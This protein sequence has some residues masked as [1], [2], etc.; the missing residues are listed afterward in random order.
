MRRLQW[1]ALISLTLACQL[2]GKQSAPGPAQTLPAR[3]GPIAEGE[4]LLADGQLDGALAQFEQAGEPQSFYYRGLVWAKKAEL[5]PLPTPYPLAPERPN[6]KASIP[7][8][9]AEEQR[10]IELYEKGIAADPNSARTY[11]ALAQ[12]LAPHAARRHDLSQ[13]RIK[14]GRAA[15][16]APAASGAEAIQP[17]RVLDL[18]RKAAALEPSA[19]EPVESLVAF[20]SRVNRRDELE[21]GLQEMLKR[22]RERPDPYIRY[23]DFLNNQRQDPTGAIE[24]Y[25]QALIWKPDDEVTRA[26]VAD[27][28]INM[29]RESFAKLQYAAT[30][31]RLAEAQKYVSD[32]NSPQGIKIQDLA[33]RLA[34][35][36]QQHN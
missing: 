35:I 2:P 21:W 28:Y 29:A 31:Q 33:G 6:E 17:Q 36:R 11:S 24:Q 1:S 20:A 27:I 23:G 9:K 18:W 16:V 5:A 12:L 32:R 13:A 26:K 25:R 7:E 15:A 30:E 10:A 22:D 3:S 4:R 8:F 19:K 34:G 14:P